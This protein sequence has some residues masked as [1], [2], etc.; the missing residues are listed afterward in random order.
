MA[1]I[2][3]QLDEAPAAR[4]VFDEIEVPRGTS[5]EQNP[6]RSAYKGLAESLTAANLL[7]SATAALGGAKDKGIRRKPDGDWDLPLMAPVQDNPVVQGITGAT[8]SG[9]QKIGA[10]LDQ[11]GPGID[12]K[13]IQ[14]IFHDFQQANNLSDDEVAAAWSDLGNLNRKW[15]DSEGARVLSD[16][17]LMP[18]AQN[19]DWLDPEKAKAIVESSAASPESKAAVLANLPD[20]QAEI[21]REK[22]AAY[23]AASSAVGTVADAN[24]AGALGAKALE[25]FT[26]PDEWAAANNRKDLG[27]PQFV[28][29]YEADVF[30]RA[31]GLK[32][33]LWGLAGKGVT[34]GT[35]LA[36]T[37]LG[38][39]GYAGSD[40]AAGLA[41]EGAEASA[42]ISQGLPDTGL[43]GAVVEELPSL[44]FQV[45]V[46]KGLGMGGKA[47]GTMGAFATAGAQSAGLTFANEI[48]DGV[49][50]EEARE[51]ATKAGINTA[52]IT[53]AFGVGSLGGVERVAA[54]NVV[55]LTLRDLHRIAREQGIASLAKSPELRK[56]AAGIAGSVAGEAT[57]EGL[58]ELIGSFLTADP[59]SNLADAWGNAVEAAKV[60]G[61]L[62]GTVDVVSRAAPMEQEA[63]Q[64]IVEAATSAPEAAAAAMEDLESST[65]TELDE[66]RLPPLEEAEPAVAPLPEVQEETAASGRPDEEALGLGPVEAQAPATVEGGVVAPDVFDEISPEPQTPIPDETTQ[67]AEGQGRRQEVLTPEDGVGTTD[68]IPAGPNA[69]SPENLATVFDLTPEQAQATDTLVRAMGL[70][71][72]QILLKKGGTPGRG[73][74]Q[75]TAVIKGI[76]GSFEVLA[77][78]GKMLLRGLSNP[79]VSTG[80]HE[81]SHVARKTL[82]DR[83]TPVAGITP[84]DIE[85]AE[86]WAGAKDGRWDTKA[87]EKFARGFEKYLRD[88]EAPV[89]ELASVF[90][91]IAE[92]F[93]GIYQSLKGTPLDLQVTP[94]MKA[95]FDA[96]VTRG[97]QI[98]PATAA[99]TPE[100]R[101]VQGSQ[102]EAT[103]ETVDSTP[104]EQ[105]TPREPDLTSTKNAATDEDLAR[106][107]FDP[108]AAPAK[109]ALGTSWD[110]ALA[111]TAAD[112]DAGTKLVEELNA[113]PRALRDDV[114]NGVLLDELAKRKLAF[115]K[116]QQD[117]VAAVESGNPVEEERTQ[118]L[119][120]DARA[121][122]YE[123]ITAAKLTGTAWGRSG[124]FRQLA[125]DEDWSLVAMENRFVTEANGGKPAS[126]AQLKE[127]K[128]LHDRIAK[129]EKELEEFRIREAERIFKAEQ[130]ARKKAKPKIRKALGSR[131]GAARKRLQEQGFLAADGAGEFLAQEALP[132]QT[133]EDLA[134]FGASW[135]VDTDLDLRNFTNRVRRTFGD[136][137]VPHAE[138]IL[139]KAKEILN[140]AAD[141][142]VEDAPVQ[143]RTRESILEDLGDTP[144]GNDIFQLA[145]L[146][147]NAG[148]EGFENVMAAVLEDLR[149]TFPEITLREIHDAYSGYGKTVFPSKAEDLVKLR[150]YRQ[151]AR[152]TSQL[153]D[154]AKG[155]APKRTGVQ[156]DKASERVRTLQKEVKRMMRQM[157]VEASDSKR[158][159][160]SL[161]AIK[162]RLKNEIE[163]LDAAIATGTPKPEP[164]ATPAYDAEATALKEQRDARKAEYDALFPKP[165]KTDEDL[166]DEALRSLDRRI[167]ENEKLVKDGLSKRPVAAKDRD[168]WSKEISERRAR[169]KELSEER[170]ALGDAEAERLERNKKLVQSRITKIRDRLEKG[171]YAPA[172]K[173]DPVLPDKELE[174]LQL[175]E[176]Q[177]KR[178][179]NEKILEARL[180]GR[181]KLERFRDNSIDLVST[182]GRALMTSFDLGHF[183]RQGGLVN[184]ARPEVT[185][186]NFKNLFTFSVDSADKVQMAIEGKTPEEKALFKRAKDA[187]LGLTEW[188]AGHKLN[189]MEELFR[190]RI[191]KKIPGV[192]ASERA[193]VS[194]MNA[195]RFDYFNTLAKALPRPT[196]ENLAELANHVNNLTGRGSLGKWENSANL[197]A[198]ILFSPKY[199]SSRL[200]VA[201][202]AL[203]LPLEATARAA[204]LDFRKKEIRDARRIIAKEYGRMAIGGSAFYGLIGLAA[205][206]AKGLAD[207]EDEKPLFTVGMD[208]TSSDFGKLVFRNGSRQDPMA[209]MSQNIVLLSRLLS[210]KSTNTEGRVTDLD[211]DPNNS[212]LKVLL[213]MGRSKLAPIPTSAVNILDKKDAQYQPT[214]IEKELLGLYLPISAAETIN[215][216]RELGVA[217][218][219][220]AAISGF[221]GQGVNTYGEGVEDKD[222]REDILTGIFRINP[223]RYEE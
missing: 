119:L 46:T 138:A 110:E 189:D 180:A 32:E 63:R 168:V 128:E 131:I 97:E 18:N 36:D 106:M 104:P 82:F 66:E 206:M 114:E 157:G 175:E 192:G 25:G 67:Q 161:D 2:F 33:K 79:D 205:M 41:G 186:R 90:S 199:W 6:R 129:A 142:A 94:A 89:P 42:L 217:G 80:I 108:I 162:N 222:I 116:A 76:K 130:E 140:T 223:E 10:R 17:T 158:L 185:V 13:A 88:G 69:Y 49:T 62:G 164:G 99:E 105:I 84:E 8:V 145:R 196:K 75:G 3:D 98:T 15:E 77:D 174:D 220:A 50:E 20:I 211:E 31:S 86:A 135:L 118:R 71:T 27:T 146:H 37:L 150:E 139:A 198:T 132:E 87:E 190:S 103:P 61:F 170:K 181:S 16:G 183:G 1:D 117:F 30:G 160:T 64:M 171:D 91:K 207:D 78:S 5:V 107:G 121:R 169:L 202:N 29:D 26:P 43:A 149:P 53:A 102:A 133:L 197:L 125:I 14:K 48:A 45:A 38:L 137:A 179:L 167:A 216:F 195:L 74:D 40:A 111:I 177:A 85:V 58:D 159:A 143:G 191:A 155:A 22:L 35:K 221:F 148:V 165:G 55:G 68:A 113:N 178:A 201:G 215:G 100:T 200:R 126:E 152:L 65:Q 204:G 218:G 52:L 163:E 154:A 112:T 122:A 54:G 60:G 57:E 123:A 208:P 59:D 176:F 28:R 19:S 172:A 203:V 144:S 166:I 173:K 47:L 124:R 70:D 23:A 193:Y 115:G 127:I 136:L 147:V 141:A 120:D 7:P 93:K 21:A 134:T 56:L 184:F 209:G 95:V 51:K 92:W 44:A 96:L 109:K 212:R 34:G 156:R 9:A 219:T 153:E 182:L 39:A 73:L 83:E 194:Y 187:G 81:L 213:R 11:A 188:R 12:Q 101:I 4:D 151:L 214:R 210:G 24:P 72:S